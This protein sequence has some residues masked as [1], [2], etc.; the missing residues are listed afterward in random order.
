[1]ESIITFNFWSKWNHYSGGGSHTQVPR[2]IHVCGWEVTP[3]VTRYSV[4]VA[5]GRVSCSWTKIVMRCS[6]KSITIFLFDMG[7]GNESTLM[8][9]NDSLV[10]HW[11]LCSVR[12]T[13]NV[14]N[15]YTFF[16]VLSLSK[17]PRTFLERDHR[18]FKGFGTTHTLKYSMS[19][20]WSR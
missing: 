16:V 20:P 14:S 9:V 15:L 10:P 2:E 8:R 1:M 17:G 13:R 18:Y 7:T 5:P 12:E 11:W 6:G 3:E 19:I 4:T